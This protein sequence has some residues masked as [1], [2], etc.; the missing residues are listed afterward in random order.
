MAKS[1]P[2]PPCTVTAL[3]STGTVLWRC[4]R[5][6]TQPPH[7]AGPLG[8]IA[9]PSRIILA[10]SDTYAN[11]DHQDNQMNKMQRNLTAFKYFIMIDL[12]ITLE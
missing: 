6:V 2:Y 7:I 5:R 11:T 9:G 8:F 10:N 12:I 1:A 3:W 4:C